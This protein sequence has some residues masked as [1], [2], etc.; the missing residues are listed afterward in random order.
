[1]VAITTLN[2]RV[3][4]RLTTKCHWRCVYFERV[5]NAPIIQN[6]SD[7]I[8]KFYVSNMNKQENIHEHLTNKIEVFTQA[9]PIKCKSTHNIELK[10]GEIGANTWASVQFV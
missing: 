10:I 3:D 1:M 6:I 8:L 7:S 9:F 2:I 4:S 5:L